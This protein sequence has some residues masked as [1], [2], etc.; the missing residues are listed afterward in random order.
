MSAEPEIVRRF[1]AALSESTESELQARAYNSPAVHFS[2]FME[3]KNKEGQWVRPVANVLQLRISEII[4]TLRELCPDIKIRIVAAKPRRA[5]LSTFSLFCGYHE[6]MRR[7]IEGLTIA[8]CRKN[9]E[10]LVEKLREYTHHDSFPWANP[11]V[12]DPEGYFQWQNGSSW[13]VD[14]AE[15]PDAG[16]GGTRQFGHFSEASKYPQTRVKNDR[17][18]MTAALPS[19]SGSGT[20]CIVESTPENAAGFFYDTF[21]E[22]MT[23]EEFVERYNAGYRPEM[24]WIR[25][26]AAWHEFA[27][28]ARKQQVS[29]MERAQIDASLTAIEKEEIE[30]YNLTYEQIAWRRETLHGECDGDEKTFAYYYPSDPVSCW[31]SSGSPRFDMNILQ[32]MKARAKYITPEYGYLVRQDNGKVSFAGTMDGSGD[33][34]IFEHPLEGKAYIVCAD[35]ATG[36]SQTVG[37]DPDANS[38]QVWR[39]KYYDPDLRQ[40]KPAKLVARVR[41]PCYDD[42]DEVGGHIHRLCHYYGVCIT[43][44]EVNQGLQVLRVLIDAGVP[45]YKRPVFNEKTNKKE[46][47]YGFKLTDK[48]QRRMVIAGL[49]AA[50]RNEEIE[51]DCLH[52]INQAMKFIVSPSGKAEA[53][54]GAHD[55]DVMCGAMAWEVLPSATV[56]ARRSVRDIDPPDMAKRGRKGGW[57]VV[58]NI[59][60][61][62]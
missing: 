53:A 44:L 56:Y 60:R 33:V 58:N 14:T 54:P 47:Q 8:D 30:K 1:R 3:I 27:D 6:A 31:L 50:I 19:F 12:R 55:D 4:E 38:V 36:E 18:T 16:V 20:I 29:E 15:N 51:V 24:Q 43:G 17:K 25:A 49:A 28:Y 34:V 21:G 13:T 9:S 5:G 22:A 32:T 40:Y 10:M 62:W 52:W 7:P 26:F 46:L 2:L 35:P 59:K 39:Q 37:A 23:L 11:L 61:G 48:Q 45:L 57:R 41:P 42:D